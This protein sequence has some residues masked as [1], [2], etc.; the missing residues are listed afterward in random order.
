MNTAL[1]SEKAKDYCGRAHDNMNQWFLLNEYKPDKVQSIQLEFRWTGCRDTDESIETTAKNLA[2]AISAIVQTAAENNQS[3]DKA[4]VPEIISDP[5]EVK[6]AIEVGKSVS[7]IEKDEKVEEAYNHIRKIFVEKL[8][9]TMLEV[10]KYLINHFYDGD[11]DDAENKPF[12]HNK[13][14]N[15]LFK[16]LQENAFGNAPK[17]TWLY[18]A[19]NLAIGENKF[20]EVS[21]YGKLGHSHKIRLLSQKKLSR[22]TKIQL[23]EQ[24]VKDNLTVNQLQE[25]INEQ[26]SGETIELNEPFPMEKLLKYDIDELKEIKKRTAERKENVLKHLKTYDDNLILVDKVIKSKPKVAKKGSKKKASK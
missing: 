8:Q 21:A 2:Y 11:Y 13:S 15:R 10:G 24:T 6:D 12:S 4:Q 26:K 22:E 25:K 5:E 3:S 20:N 23:M 16:K 19:I 17:K 18:D 7:P 9:E 14:L 1:T